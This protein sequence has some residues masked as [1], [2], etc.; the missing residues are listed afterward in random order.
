MPLMNRLPLAVGLVTFAAI[1]AILASPSPAVAEKPNIVVILADDLGYGDLGCY[2]TESKVPTP[3]LDRLAREGMRFTQAYCPVSVCSPSRYAM[4]TGQYPFRSWKKNGVL[5]NWDKPMIA[6]RQ[7]TLPALLKQAGYKTA[8]FGKWHLG[9]T[10]KTLDGKPP[11]GQGKFKS[12]DTGANIDLAA[13]VAGG[14]T[15]RGFDR[16]YGFICASE[17]LIFDQDKAVALLSHSLYEPPPVPGAKELPGVTVAQLL[18]QIT[19]K[20]VAYLVDHAKARSG[21]PFFLYFAPYVPHI[22]LAVGDDFRGRT[23]AGDYGDYVHQL[24]HEI[25]RLLKSLDDTGLARD[26]LVFFATD[27][28]SEFLKS[29]DNHQPNGILRGRKHQI[30][31]GGVRTPL[32]VRWPGQVQE[33]AVSNNIAGLNDLLATVADLIGQQLPPT[34]GRDS[35]SLLPILLGKQTDQ[36]VRDQILLQASARHYALREGDW[37]YI[38]PNGPNAA[39]LYDLQNDPSE[40]KNLLKEKPELAEELRVKLQKILAGK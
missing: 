19:D 35:V 38:Q 18:P 33:N 37:K 10:Y 28:G 13:P 12:D 23:R 9:A 30:Y 26:T 24:D 31:E 25:G 11:A 15:D 6:D 8:G 21:A 40:S 16:W 29:G 1:L 22:P 27:N 20:S 17:M 2:Q 34:A 3:N 39:E 7:L 32:L 36:P 4:M 5:A 14:P